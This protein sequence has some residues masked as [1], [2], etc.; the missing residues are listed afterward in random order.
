MHFHLQ[1]RPSLKYVHDAS[2]I[3]HPPSDMCMSSEP[4]S[5]LLQPPSL[6]LIYQLVVPKMASEWHTVGVLCG[7]SAEVLRVIREDDRDTT[8]CCSRMFESWLEKAPGT[9][10]RPRAWSTLLEAVQSGYGAATREGIEAEL[11]SWKPEG[12]G[13]AGTTRDKVSMHC[14]A[15]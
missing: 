3:P 15:R 14:S 13:L 2:S 4:N 7:V 12:E 6:E 10:N 11:L 1:C 8:R 5:T 9:G